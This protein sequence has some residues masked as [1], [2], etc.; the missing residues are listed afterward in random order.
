MGSRDVADCR[1]GGRGFDAG[2]GGTQSE[3]DVAGSR[4]QNGGV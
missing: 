4:V 1:D 3:V 2:D